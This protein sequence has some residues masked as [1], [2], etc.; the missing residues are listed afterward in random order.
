MDETNW[1]ECTEG[2]DK[3]PHGAYGAAITDASIDDGELWIGNGEY[4]SRVNFCPWCGMAAEKP[5]AA[6][7]LGSREGP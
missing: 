7:D 1:H 6:A 2:M 4:A 5:V 3:Y